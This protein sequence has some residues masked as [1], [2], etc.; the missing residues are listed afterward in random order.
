[1]KRKSIKKDI[2]IIGAG[3][4]GCA[5]A[6]ELSRFKKKVLVVEKESDVSSGTTKANSGIIHAGYAESPGTLR[7]SLCRKGNLLF[8][9]NAEEL[10]IQ[11]KNT[12]SLVNIL[13]LSEI[14]VL[15]RLLI[16]GK[17]NGLT[18]LKIIY[19]SEN[20]KKIEPNINKK[21]CASLLAKEAS[22]TSPYGAAFALY[23]NARL[24][25]VEFLFN[26][27][28]NE[29][30]FVKPLKHFFLKTPF[31]EIETEILV[32]AAGIFAHKI[33]NMIGDNS[34]E[35]HPAKGEYLVF[36]NDTPGLVNKINFSSPNKSTKGVVVTPTVDNNIL[37]G[38][39]FEYTDFKDSSTTFE[40]LS[41]IKQKAK[42]LFPELPFKKV[43][44]SF[45]GLRAVSNTNDFIIGSS[46]IN[47]KFINIGGIQSPGLTCAFS[48]TQIVIDILRDLK[49]D[50]RHNKK[51]YPIRKK[52]ERFKPDNLLKKFG[53]FS[54]GENYNEI[55]CRCEN[56]TKAE[57]IEAIKRGATDIDGIKLRTRAGMGRCQ[58]GY[59]LLRVM[60]IIFEELDIHYEEITKKGNNSRIIKTRMN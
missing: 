49:I 12:G 32:N 54:L 25:G 15:E 3:I 57:I 1:M 46:C 44:S 58:G 56:V 8:K 4:I 14:K 47:N 38:P 19:G 30:D 53:K 11:L 37:A 28:V 36:D 26:S 48:I 43:I 21:V 23:E 40:G 29:I 22:I 45:A 59:C 24:N 35:I 31:I 42:D 13:N 41:E 39:N 60:K 18:D 34:F 52:I 2:V 51:F 33:A 20:I 10:D 16:N 6:R 27:V 50:L 5:I 17:A 55:I 9:K 7:S